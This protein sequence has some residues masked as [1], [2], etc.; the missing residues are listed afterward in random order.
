MLSEKNNTE[1]SIYRR[2]WSQFHYPKTILYSSYSDMLRKESK[3]F[4][5]KVTK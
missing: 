5:V 3:L 4:I 2:S 1:N